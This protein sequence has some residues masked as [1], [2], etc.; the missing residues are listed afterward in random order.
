MSPRA[1]LEYLAAI[2]KRY[3][4]VSQMIKTAILKE[5]FSTRGY[6]RKHALQLLPT[7][8]PA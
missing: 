8:G 4:A 6:H 2:V 5:F 7:F 3:R 1:K